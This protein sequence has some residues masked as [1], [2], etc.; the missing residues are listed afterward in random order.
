[1]REKEKNQDNFLRER[2]SVMGWAKINGL[3]YKD[4]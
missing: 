2:G 4:F 1:V 3:S